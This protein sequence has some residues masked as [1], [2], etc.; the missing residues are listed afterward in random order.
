M[1]IGMRRT[2]MNKTNFNLDPQLESSSIWIQ[3]LSLCQLR[4]KNDRRFPWVLLIPR[5]SN[6]VE[7]FDL[8]PT[9]QQQLWSEI[10]VVT[11]HM[12]AHFKAH[13]MNIEALGNKVRQLHIHIIARFETDPAW[14]N[15]I[16]NFGTAEAYPPEQASEVAQAL[17][18]LT[19]E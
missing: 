15:S 1:I 7:I 9:D 19:I 14:P 8:S 10:S 11:Q 2:Q 4:L 5:R 12:H 17:S 13:K 18:S 16:L 6:I 3:D